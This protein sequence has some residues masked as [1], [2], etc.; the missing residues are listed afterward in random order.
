MMALLFC[1]EARGKIKCT[2]ASDGFILAY[3]QKKFSPSKYIKE[4]ALRVGV[5]MDGLEV[6]SGLLEAS[7]AAQPCQALANSLKAALGYSF[8]SFARE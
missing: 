3:R 4:K 6:G 8:H 7:R 5:W 1:L 2:K